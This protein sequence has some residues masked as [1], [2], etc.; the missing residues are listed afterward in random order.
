VTLLRENVTPE[1]AGDPWSDA[2]KDLKSNKD[3]RLYL[4]PDVTGDP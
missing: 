3:A 4:D 1:V 2:A